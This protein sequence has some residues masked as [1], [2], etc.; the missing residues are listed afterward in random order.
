MTEKHVADAEAQFHILSVTP[1]FCQVGNSVVPFDIAQTMPPEKAKYAKTV[2]ARSKPVLMIDS[3]IEG[4]K[5][6]AGSGVQSQVSLGGGHSKI[7]EGSS[8]VFIENRMA[9]RHDDLVDMNC[10]VIG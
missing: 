8:T 3:L 2:F 4:V 7:A 10:R 9:A 5:G 1:D 6:N